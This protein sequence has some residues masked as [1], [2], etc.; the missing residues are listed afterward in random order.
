MFNPMDPTVKAKWLEALR[1][2]KY[3]QGAGSLRST[4]PSGNNAYCC[5]GVLCDLRDPNGWRSSDVGEQKMA[6][7]V[8]HQ[9][10]MPPTEVLEWANL[11]ER[12]DLA[13]SIPDRLAE[14]NDLG[15]DFLGIADWIEE[16][17]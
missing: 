15:K 8:A 6:Y 5:L 9:F 2:G 14:M 7:L 17:L 11:G 3:A 13:E 1:S 10:L 12:N 4:S 16:N